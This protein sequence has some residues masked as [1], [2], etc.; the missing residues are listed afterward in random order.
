[1]AEK[2]IGSTVQVKTIVANLA[3]GDIGDYEKV[4]KEASEQDISILVNN[5]GCGTGFGKLHKQNPDR[6]V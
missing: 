1:M 6:L 2:E 4:W 3:S 5:V